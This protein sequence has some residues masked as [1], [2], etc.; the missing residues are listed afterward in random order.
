M[1]YS[2]EDDLCSQRGLQLAFEY[3]LPRVAANAKITY[4]DIATKLRADLSIE[5]KVFPTHVGHVIGTLMHRILD[6][7][8]TAPL[9]NV[10]VVNQKTGEPGSGANFFLRSRFGTLR[11]R[12]ELIR[13]A[14]REVYAYAGWSRIYRKLFKTEP[15]AAPGSLVEGTEV[16]GMPPASATKQPRGGPAESDEHKRLKQHVE[17]HPESVGA[18]A[19]PRQRRKEMKLLSGDEVDVFFEY[20]DA[21]YLIEVKSVLSSDPDLERGVY[22][23]IK[24]RAVFEAQRSGTAPK[25]IKVILVTEIT[26]SA[27][28]R[29]LAKQHGVRCRVVAVNRRGG[30]KAASL[31][32]P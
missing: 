8:S 19:R 21:A 25:A 5:G 16:D 15:P 31:A 10:L 26:P 27:K 30:G 2:I 32:A 24:Y 9:V 23:C 3:L 4:G 7:E 12:G 1:P 22:Q 20:R 13:Q 14:A 18:P 6:A 11:R 29:D 17:D 28:I